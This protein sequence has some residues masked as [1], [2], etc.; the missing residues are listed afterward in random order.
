[1][2]KFWFLWLL[3]PISGFCQTDEQRLKSYANLLITNQKVNNQFYY[4]DIRERKRLDTLSASSENYRLRMLNY[5]WRKEYE[6]AE[7]W[8]EKTTGLYPKQHG[9]VGELYLL[10]LRDYPRALVH[11]DTYDA[12]TPNFDDIV[13]YNPVSYMKGLT[14]RAMGNH[15]KALEQ[16]SIGIDSLTHKHGAEWVNYKH[17]VSRAVSYIATQQPEKALTDLE[18]AAKNFS[19]SALV[20]YHR[21]RALLQLNRTDEARSAFQDASFFFKALRAERTSDYQ[22]DD[23]NS[24]YEPEIDDA[25]ANLKTQRP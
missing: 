16:F 3:L 21:G 19:R 5:L 17:Y 18:K 4:D 11:F 25:L 7:Q 14:Y 15:Q 8:M 13:G 1:M 12:L 9:L 22:E 6:Q 2:R 20:Q 23:F 24:L 10:H